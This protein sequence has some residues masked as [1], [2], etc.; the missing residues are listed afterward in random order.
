MPTM[1]DDEEIDESTA[2]E[3]EV[4]RIRRNV[5]ARMARMALW[6]S[7]DM[8]RRLHRPRTFRLPK[9]GRML[10][11]VVAEAEAAGLVPQ[12]RRRARAGAAATRRRAR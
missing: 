2:F 6:K 9:M 8:R 1:D 11:A 10:R 5:A 4:A 3:D 12:A 7:R